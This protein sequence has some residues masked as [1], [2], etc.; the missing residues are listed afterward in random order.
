[1]KFEQV[2]G[3]KRDPGDEVQQLR[4]QK[5]F[6]ALGNAAI[7]G[8][9]FCTG[10]IDGTK[11]V[12]ITAEKVAEYME[13]SGVGGPSEHSL[14]REDGRVVYLYKVGEDDE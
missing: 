14:T 7:D 9:G 5:L 1:M 10:E 12:V 13:R 4:Q 3:G 11:V 8:P 6:E 2:G